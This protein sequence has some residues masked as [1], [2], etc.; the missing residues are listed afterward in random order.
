MRIFLSIFLVIAFSL[1]LNLS[2]AFSHESYLTGKVEL[3]TTHKTSSKLK[4]A[5]YWYKNGEPQG[6]KGELWENGTSIEDLNRRRDLNTAK[7]TKQQL[8]RQNIVKKQ[9]VAFNHNAKHQLKSIE[10]YDRTLDDKPLNLAAAQLDTDSLVEK[11]TWRPTLTEPIKID[12]PVLKTQRSVF[13]AYAHV[14][15]DGNFHVS[16]GPEVHLAESMYSPLDDKNEPP[17][18][19]ELGMGMKFLWN[20]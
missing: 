19:A 6:D 9:S 18:N 17:T 3:N 15:D 8:N 20:F 11:N 5:Q 10:E 1:G 12:E 14:V 16:A 7:N 4:P 13:G 2:E